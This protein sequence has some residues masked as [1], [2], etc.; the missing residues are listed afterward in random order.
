MKKHIPNLITGLNAASGAMAVFMALY[1]DVIQ[2][3]R[4]RRYALFSYRWG[5]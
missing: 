1:V 3:C 4:C 2:I 5:P